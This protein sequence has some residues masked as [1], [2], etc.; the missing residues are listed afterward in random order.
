MKRFW[1]AYQCTFPNGKHL[2]SYNYFSS[3]EDLISAVER[4][5]GTYLAECGGYSKLDRIFLCETKAKA[6]DRAAELN[7]FFSRNGTYAY[8]RGIYQF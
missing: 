2:A 7:E 3:N 1:F 4:F 8:D 5:G 6:E